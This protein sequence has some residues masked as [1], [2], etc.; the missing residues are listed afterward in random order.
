MENLK[1]QGKL[2]KWGPFATVA[3]FVAVLAVAIFAQQGGGG[4]HESEV[5]TAGN[6]LSTPVIWS[7]GIAIPLRGV[8]GVPVFLGESHV[9]GSFVWYLQQDELNEWQAETA[10]LSAEPF[11]VDWIDW[12][13]NLE[14]RPWTDRSI[15]RTEVVL[16]EDLE[17]PMRGFVM[18]WLWGDGPDEMWGTNGDTY[19]S[20]SA[21]IYSGCARF[22]IQKFDEGVNP[23][24]AL[25]S[26]NPDNHQWEG[27]ISNPFFNGSVY[28]GGGEGPASGYSAEINVSGKVIYG[29]NWN[30]RKAGDG[31]GDYRLTFSLDT[32]VLF[33]CNTFFDGDTKVKPSGEESAQVSVQAEPLGGK[34]HILWQNNLT[35]IDIKIIAAKGKGSPGGG[36]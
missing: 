15:V 10:D 36:K 35:Y 5:E 23:E 2:W 26:W 19:N 33:G 20:S 6:N 9:D 14:A 34:A 11:Y 7:D 4:G 24:T 21:T 25:V 29:Y 32:D 13:D 28:E 8:F 18:Q 27:E 31:A 12:G 22:V 30:V 17:F 3:V 16:W 1:C